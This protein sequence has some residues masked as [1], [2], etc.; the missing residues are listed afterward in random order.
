MSE[1]LL[2]IRG[3]SK[4]FGGI[5]ANDAISLD[6]LK[7][8]IVGLTGLKGSGKTTL[9]NSIVGYVLVSG[10]LAKAGPG[11]ELLADADVGRL[12]LGG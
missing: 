8:A 12:F 10:R 3:A 11:E 5:V 1:A 9:L 4:A 7:G 6:V 2:A